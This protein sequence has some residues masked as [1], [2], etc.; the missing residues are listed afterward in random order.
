[1]NVA[2]TRF[3]R[4]SVALV[5]ASLWRWR[6]CSLSLS[7]LPRQY[8]RRGRVEVGARGEVAQGAANPVAAGEHLREVPI[9]PTALLVSEAARVAVVL[10]APLVGEAARDAVVFSGAL[11][12]GCRLLGRGAP[13]GHALLAQFKIGGHCLDSVRLAWVYLQHD[14]ERMQVEHDPTS[15]ILE[16]MR[17]FMEAIGGIF[18]AWRLES[19]AM[20]AI[21]AE[22][23]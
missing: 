20:Q 3:P 5:L 16:A 19:R 2:A 9:A 22:Q 17:G 4:S 12:L 1:M 7:S 6:T 11:L 21:L 18:Y 8:F 13:L 15:A 10:L 23:S 14:G